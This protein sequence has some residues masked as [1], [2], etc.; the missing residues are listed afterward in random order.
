M[1]SA[2]RAAPIRRGSSWVPPSPGITPT[3]TSGSPTTAVSSATTRSLSRAS[4][5]PAAEGVPATAAVTTGTGTASSA[6]AIRRYTTRWAR[7]CS[8]L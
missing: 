2:A 8:S 1:S 7:S 4:S 6:A 5:K 3:D